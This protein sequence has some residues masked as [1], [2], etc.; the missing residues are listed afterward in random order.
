MN[1][2]RQNERQL[3]V[4]PLSDARAPTGPGNRGTDRPWS[5]AVLPMSPITLI[6]VLLFSTNSV[7]VA[8]DPI[9]REIADYNRAVRLYRAG[10]VAAARQL[11][12]DSAMS[13]DDDLAA[14]ARFNAGNCNYA[15]ALQI[16]QQDPAAAIVQLQSAISHYRSTLAIDRNDEDAR[17]NL[18][19][20]AKLIEQ[21]SDQQDQQQQSAQQSGQPPEQPEQ[22]QSQ[23]QESQQQ[24]VSTTRVSTTTI[25][26]NKSLSSEN[27]SNNNNNSNSKTTPMRLTSNQAMHPQRTSK[28]HGKRTNSNLA[29]NNPSSPISLHRGK[30]NKQPNKNQPSA[31]PQTSRAVANRKTHPSNHQ[32]SHKKASR[33]PVRR[34]S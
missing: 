27:P 28:N 17:T 15:T 24:Q 25:S 31:K 18:E 8:S 14:K 34:V 6:A 12:T 22:Q 3:R 7:A 30:R 1:Q 2:R 4:S 32:T 33:R 13:L 20:A 21:L 5:R 10:D 29:N 19:L 23:Q 16:R 11:F 9:E 26:N